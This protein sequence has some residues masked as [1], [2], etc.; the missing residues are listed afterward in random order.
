MAVERTPEEME[1]ALA[2]NDDLLRRFADGDLHALP[3]LMEAMTGAR[4][5]SHSV[6]EP[7]EQ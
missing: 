3:S 4:V 1:Q 5:V 7:V 6:P 2:D